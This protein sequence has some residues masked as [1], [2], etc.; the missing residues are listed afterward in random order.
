MSRELPRVRRPDRVDLLA[1]RQVVVALE[2]LL[3]QPQVKHGER[4][5]TRKPMEVT[6][7][8]SK[9]HGKVGLDE[10]PTGIG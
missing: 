3:R 10:G 7:P 4:R 6:V 2:I 8:S 9:A 5:R 1:E